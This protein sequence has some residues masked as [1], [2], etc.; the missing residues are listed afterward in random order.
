[1]PRRLLLPLVIALVPGCSGDAPELAPNPETPAA[2][3][4]EQPESAISSGHALAANTEYYLDGP[5]QARPPDGTLKAGTKVMVI[6]DA[7]SY[8]RVRSEDGIVAF[9]AADAIK[10]PDVADPQAAPDPVL[11]NGGKPKGD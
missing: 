11:G 10:T 6:E 4:V 5:Q 9:I 8:C 1:M 3:Q 2:P 7:G